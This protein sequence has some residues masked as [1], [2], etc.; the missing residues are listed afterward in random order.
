M[1]NE[2]GIRVA[3]VFSKLFSERLSY[4]RKLKAWTQS[5]QWH[6]QMKYKQMKFSGKQIYR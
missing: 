5:K 6:K 3:L 4:L 1:S 2:I